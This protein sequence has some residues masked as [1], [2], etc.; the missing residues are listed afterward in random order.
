HPTALIQL[1]GHES[2][3][4]VRNVRAFVLK[5]VRVDRATL[6]AE[7]DVWRRA[8]ADAAGALD[9]LKGLVLETAGPGVG[10]TG[11]AND[12]TFVA[13]VARRGGFAGLPPIVA[14]GGLTSET[15]GDVVRA[16]RPWAVDVSSGVERVKGEKAPD[17][18]EGFVRA[19]READAD[20]GK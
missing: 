17:L 12:W 18:V 13:D 11:Q 20:L 8:I 16:I 15:V 1:H 14:A 7:L 19:V 4:F 2:P 9:H 6:E 3:A 10:G 5:A